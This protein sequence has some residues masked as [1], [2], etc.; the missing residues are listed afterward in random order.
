MKSLN[1]IDKIK[2]SADANGLE[3]NI[4]GSQRTIAFYGKS[5]YKP[6]KIIS[7]ANK[8]YLFTELCTYLV[9]NKPNVDFVAHGEVDYTA[10]FVEGLFTVEI[11][12]R[13]NGYN[14]IS[15]YKTN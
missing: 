7:A 8:Q 12:K 2:A 6:Y 15:I 14:I 4:S 11:Q 10:S 9:R 13:I 1:I 5:L 3:L